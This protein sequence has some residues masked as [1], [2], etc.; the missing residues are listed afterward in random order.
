MDQC[1]ATQINAGQSGANCFFPFIQNLQHDDLF[2]SSTSPFVRA[3]SRN[4]L[5]VTLTL[6]VENAP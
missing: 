2:L 6:A 4:S 3:Q 5:Y 1:K